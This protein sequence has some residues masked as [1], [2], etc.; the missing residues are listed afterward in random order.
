MIAMSDESALA[1]PSSEGP[2]EDELRESKDSNVRPSQPEI[3]S[4]EPKALAK[5]PKIR[6]DHLLTHQPAHPACDVC[7]QAKLRAH[8]HRRF[9]NQ[10]EAQR[11]AQ[12]I[13]A[14]K[15][16]LQAIAID[17]LESTGEGSNGELYALICVDLILVLCLR[18]QHRLSPKKQLSELWSIFKGGEIHCSHR[19]VSFLLAALKHLNFSI[20]PSIPSGVLHNS[21]AEAG[22]RVVRQGTRTLLLQSEGGGV[23]DS[24][25]ASSGADKDDVDGNFSTWESKLHL[26]LTYQPEIRPVPFGASVWY[27]DPTRPK[28]F[29]PN[30]IP[31]VYV[32]PEVL[33]GLRC[34]DVH[35]LYDS[36]GANWS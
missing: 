28:F 33:P 36:G 1:R 4:E 27:R 25:A 10:A 20:E 12:A 6:V 21:S 18:I 14:P 30:G 9:K 8:A 35:V 15:T 19:E 26:A 29:K 23:A 2:H 34:K 22:I 3:L 24:A 32:G 11:V 13:E 7:R 5:Q 17:H 31:A 16:L